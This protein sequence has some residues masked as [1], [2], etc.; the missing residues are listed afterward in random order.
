MIWLTLILLGIAQIICFSLI[1]ALAQSKKH[2]PKNV[3]YK[4]QL[5][6]DEL[7]KIDI[8][9]DERTRIER[10]RSELNSIPLRVVKTFDG[11]D[12]LFEW[13]DIKNNKWKSCSLDPDNPMVLYFDEK[14]K[15]VIEATFNRF[16]GLP[17][18]VRRRVTDSFYSIDFWIETLIKNTKT[19]ISKDGGDLLNK[20]QPA[21][22][23]KTFNLDPPTVINDDEPKLKL[24]DLIDENDTPA[25]IEVL[26][27]IDKLNSK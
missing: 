22:V 3:V 10:I 26:K 4:S 21:F 11:G 20:N 8:L 12:A 16:Q 13:F 24:V 23:Y 18:D 5:T 15:V 17:L 7:K 1:F 27:R 9:N 25:E 19:F 2:A 14:P 6:P